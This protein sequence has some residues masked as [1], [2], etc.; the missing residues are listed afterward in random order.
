M[1]SGMRFPSANHE[2]DPVVAAQQRELQRRL[3]GAQ[4]VGEL[5]HR[6]YPRAPDADDDV[7]GAQTVLERSA[8][9]VDAGDEDA[10]D[11]AVHRHPRLDVGDLET[12]ELRHTLADDARRLVELADPRADLDLPALAEHGHV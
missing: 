12:S 2:L 8:L 5:L 6:A 7:A 4:A 11:L 10:L 9:A 1:I 3:R